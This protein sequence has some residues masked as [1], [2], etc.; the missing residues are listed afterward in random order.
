M[1][2]AFATA[3]LTWT[4]P[5]GPPGSAARVEPYSTADLFAHFPEPDT[6]PAPSAL[7]SLDKVTTTRTGSG[8]TQ[9][10]SVSLTQHLLGQDGRPIGA[11]QRCTMSVTLD[12]QPSG[13]WLVGGFTLGS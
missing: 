5:D 4:S 13:D 9:N 3:Y 7:A 8:L 2:A 10:V 12:Q 11:P 1:A 6:W